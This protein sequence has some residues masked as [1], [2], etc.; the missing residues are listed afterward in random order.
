[1]SDPGIKGKPQDPAEQ[2][3]DGAE[4]PTAVAHQAWRGQLLGEGVSDKGSGVS[5]WLACALSYTGPGSAGKAP[6][7][8]ELG[9]SLLQESGD[10][11]RP[12]GSTQSRLLV[13]CS[14]RSLLVSISRTAEQGQS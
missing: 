6:V 5:F 12:E 7:F 2:G 9:P 4:A 10:L 1:M 14:S 3:K 13:P 8:L 11:S